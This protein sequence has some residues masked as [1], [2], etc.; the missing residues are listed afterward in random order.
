MDVFREEPEMGKGVWKIQRTVSLC[1]IREQRAA[2]GGKLNQL[3][4][5]HCHKKCLTWSTSATKFLNPMQNISTNF[6]HGVA[7]CRLLWKVFHISTDVLHGVYHFFLHLLIRSSTAL[8]CTG[9]ATGWGTA[10][11]TCSNAGSW[12]VATW[13]LLKS[14]VDASLEWGK[15]HFWHWLV[16]QSWLSSSWTAVFNQ[17][18]DR[19]GLTKARAS[20][21]GPFQ[22]VWMQ[23]V[24]T[25]QELIWQTRLNGQH[26]LWLDG[27]CPRSLVEHRCLSTAGP[28][29]FDWSMLTV[30]TI[31]L[32]C[33]MIVIWWCYLVIWQWYDIVILGYDSYMIWW[34]GDVIWGLFEK[35]DHYKIFRISRNVLLSIPYGIYC[36]V[37]SAKCRKQFSNFK[38]A[39]KKGVEKMKN[40]TGRLSKKPGVAHS[41]FDVARL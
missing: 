22:L 27:A 40:N 39:F 36:R 34:Y 8:Q 41:R 32:S 1:D 24:T 13:V 14:L 37:C 19:H 7:I 11:K 6:L 18:L 25:S 38:K 35:V 15:L 16:K 4:P 9:K 3:V 21:L 5:A 26:G 31:V 10:I 17:W 20:Q 33:D 29:M 30:L 2:K 28:S 23:P 12:H